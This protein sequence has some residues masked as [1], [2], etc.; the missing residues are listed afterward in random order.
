MI[1]PKCSTENPGHARFCG[2]CGHSL[3]PQAGPAATSGAG[4]AANFFKWVGYFFTG[5][6]LLGILTNL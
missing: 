3:A 5:L 1:C 4:K 6:I 2:T